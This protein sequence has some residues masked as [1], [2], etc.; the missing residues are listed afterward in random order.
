M[1]KNINTQEGNQVTATATQAKSLMSEYYF[2]KILDNFYEMYTR[3]VE[4]NEG[5]YM[6]WEFNSIDNKVRLKGRVDYD[7]NSVYT[8]ESYQKEAGTKKHYQKSYNAD[9]WDEKKSQGVDQDIEDILQVIVDTYLESQGI[10]QTKV[11]CEWS[12]MMDIYLQTQKEYISK[13][14]FRKWAQVVAIYDGQI[15][16]GG[17]ILPDA[18]DDDDQMVQQ[19]LM[20]YWVNSEVIGAGSK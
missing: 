11:E 4:K 8:I 7:R 16:E 9:Q 13:K 17:W 10:T 14:G 12:N 15:I 5:G 20:V 2:N 19:A 6:T 18:Q 1:S 3:Y